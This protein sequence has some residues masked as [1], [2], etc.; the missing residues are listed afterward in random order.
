MGGAELGGVPET[1]LWTLRNRALEAAREGSYLDDPEAVRIYEGLVGDSEDFDRFG[2]LSQTHALRALAVD[3]AIKE[4]WVEHPRRPV[5]ALGEGL[6]TT[7]WRLGRPDVQWYSVDLPEMIEI[8]QRLLPE[9]KAITR[10]PKIIPGVA[11]ARDVIPPPGRGRWGN[12]VLRL[13]GQVP[14]LRDQRPSLTLLTFAE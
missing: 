6:Q 9:E 3:A 5:V 13:L 10:I 12:P 8:Q 7:Y 4:F 11:S 2:K 1:A 14:V